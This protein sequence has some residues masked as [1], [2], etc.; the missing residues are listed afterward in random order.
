MD[1]KEMILSDEY[2]DLILDFPV[3]GS[4]PSQSGN[5][6]YCVLPVTAE[7][8]IVYTPRNSRQRPDLD[9]Y[10]YRYMPKLY[11]L[12][13][14]SFDPISLTESGIL[15]V[16]NPPL[17]LTGK[18]V[19]L[20]F[21]DTGIDYRNEVFQ[22][23]DGSS[24]IL[25]LWDQTIQSGIPPEGFLYGSE[26]LGGEIDRAL[27]SPNPYEVVPSRDEIGHGTAMAAVACGSAL[28][29][30]LTFTGAAPDADIVVVKLKECKP[31]LR[32]YYLISDETA[33]SET[34][35]ML[36]VK[37]VQQFL[38][39][40]ERP[41]V[42]CLG[43][44]TN[45][46]DHTGSSPLARYL[47]ALATRRSMGIVVC[48]GNEGNAAHHYAGQI[49]P[50]DDRRAYQDVEIR[51]GEGIGGFFLEFWGNALDAYEVEIRSPGG[52][53]VP[54]TDLGVGQSINYGFVYERTKVS[55]YNVLVE[56][57]AG[58][59]LITMRFETPTAGIW[60]IRV[61]GRDSVRN[62]TFHMWLPITAFLTGETYFLESEPEITL[63]E[64][65]NGANII[66]VSAYNDENNS[67]F[68]ASG[69]GY[70]RNGRIKPDFS[71]PG[72]NVSSIRG[73]Y[74]GSSMAAA[75]TGGGIAQFM[76]WAVVENNREFV[77]S[78]DVRNYLIRGAQRE[79]GISYPDRMWGYG[80]LDIEGTFDAIAG[81]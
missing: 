33:Y 67:F 49:E 64:P 26:Y 47:S 9:E 75:I 25:A 43:I 41:V 80:R 36:G 50:A 62:G 13:Q 6:E 18:G 11:G 69:R 19:I 1:C 48:G 14:F 16:Q 27:Q 63:T 8:Q 28:N 81:V 51:V 42:L 29:D 15:S 56:S 31:Y 23:P 38:V 72:V 74:T 22:R 79:R 77:T 61:R 39:S 66:T 78:L 4:A 68:I 58:E 76:Q 60:R 10:A 5:G 35:V 46:G 73:D 3:G 12:M 54:G 57:D 55:V 44:G 24:R 71:A 20:A 53:T 52:E 40:F 45:W 34:D 59:Q 2:A 65:S 32:D 7:Q 30:G 70:A 17:S 37:Y 21:V